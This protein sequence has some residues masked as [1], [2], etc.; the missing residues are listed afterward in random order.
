MKYSHVIAKLLLVPAYAIVIC[1]FSLSSGSGTATAQ[2]KPQ[3][4]AYFDRTL[5]LPNYKV[6]I[7]RNDAVCSMIVSALNRG[8]PEPGGLYSDGI[9]AG[10]TD[11]EPGLK[12][13]EYNGNFPIQ[14]ALRASKIDWIAAPVFNDGIP[15]YVVRYWMW[16]FGGE[17]QPIEIKNS[18]DYIVKK[19]YSEFGTDFSDGE[20]RYRDI[21]YL[22]SYGRHPLGPD[23]ISRTRP[24]ILWNNYNCVF[25]D[26]REDRTDVVQYLRATGFYTTSPTEKEIIYLG[27]E[28]FFLI[29]K[30][31]R[32]VFAII[33]FNSEETFEE[34][35]FIGPDGLVSGHD[36]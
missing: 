4:L 33:K 1:S 22:Y 12:V 2:T 23:F 9:F 32:E 15:R 26:D 18:F 36:R 7:S 34:V 30:I 27:G 19:R 17:G 25:C 5:P 31:Y 24:Q 16:G 35:C 29:R 6:A 21:F 11:I 28:F 3:K 14:G 20:E 10:W 13:G 8:G